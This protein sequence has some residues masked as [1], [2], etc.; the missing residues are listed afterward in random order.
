MMEGVCWRGVVCGRGVVSIIGSP[1]PV[2]TV[3]SKVLEHDCDGRD[4]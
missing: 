1:R 4:D 3:F 2:K